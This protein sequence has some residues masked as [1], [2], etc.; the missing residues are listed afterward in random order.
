MT[1]Q[2]VVKMISDYASAISN[3]GTN[4]FVCGGFIGIF[5]G[6][7]SVRF[8]DLITDLIDYLSKKRDKKDKEKT[9]E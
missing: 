4:Y 5:I 2:E 6:V 8:L 1:E 9:D 3:F 7:L